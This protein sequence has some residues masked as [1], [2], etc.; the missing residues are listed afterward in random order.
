MR[1]AM[2]LFLSVSL[3]MGSL[4][5][6][7]TQTWQVRVWWP[8]ALY[9]PDNTSAT[10]ILETQLQGFDETHSDIQVEFR[11][12][13][14]EGQG[15]IITTLLTAEEV[16]PNALPDLVL[17]RQ[18]DLA[19]AVQ[20]GVAK[21]MDEWLPDSIR[22]DLLPNALSLGQIDGALYGLPYT[23]MVD[24]LAYR[25]DAFEIPPLTYED[26]LTS[27]T[28]IFITGA[29]PTA[30]IV[31]NLILA[32]YLAL[33]GRLID[34]NGQPI[35]DE[36]PLTEVLEF[37]EQG[38]AQEIF[39]PKLLEYDL[40]MDYWAQFEQGDADAALVNS[41]DFL[42]RPV[43][44]IIA[45]PFPTPDG[46][47]LTIL[48]GYMWALTTSIPEQ[49]AAALEFLSWMMRADQQADYTEALGVLPSLAPAL[50]I[51]SKNAYTDQI[52]AWLPESIILPV[53]QRDNPAAVQLQ[54]A[55]ASVLNG[56]AAEQ[57]VQT[58]L[59]TLNGG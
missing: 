1:V 47:S 28:A 33:G 40:P 18:E 29:P 59:Q 42:Q 15:S 57:A 44:E 16:A 21:P 53:E 19:Q 46:S 34:E 45:A 3:T 39:T 12:K 31:N 27:E 13:H 41:T 48:D 30:Q 6:Q 17:L 5:A 36:I 58:A 35:L 4:T 25:P 50:R 49:Q 10:D 56:T 11:L 22:D 26:A 7:E 51:W 43:N 55:F 2:L 32:Q 20:S 8:D 54:A 9:S 52:S 23:L 37:Y 14:S 24:H 38:L